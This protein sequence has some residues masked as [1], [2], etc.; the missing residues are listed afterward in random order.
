MLYRRVCTIVFVLFLQAELLISDDVLDDIYNGNIDDGCEGD[1]DGGLFVVVVVV[2][3]VIFVIAVSMTSMKKRSII[4]I[5]VTIFT[6]TI[7]TKGMNV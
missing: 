5:S 3:F 6:I 1:E 2:I 7:I 4:I